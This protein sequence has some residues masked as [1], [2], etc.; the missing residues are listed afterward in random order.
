MRRPAMMR[1]LALPA[2]A[3]LL[4]A[5]VARPVAAIDGVLH[6]LP[7]ETT[8]E[9]SAYTCIAASAAGRVYVGT[10][11]YGGSG[12]LCELDPAVGQW[13]KVF[14]AHQLTRE[15]GVGLNSQSKFH[16]KIVIDAD[17]VVWAATKQGNEEFDTRPEYG[18]DPTGYPGGH[19][20]SYDP[21]TGRVT[22]HGIL[23]KQEGLMGGAVDNQRRR[24]YYW[25]DPKQHFL[26][27]DIAANKVTDKGNMGGSPRYTPIDRQGRVFGH[28][29]PARPDVMLMYDPETDKLSDLVIQLDGPG[30]YDVPYTTVLSADGKSLFCCSVVGNR[31]FE[32]DLA[33]VKLEPPGRETVP[34]TNGTIRVIDRGET[35]APPKGHNRH[36]GVLGADGCFY[37]QDWTR[38]IR[39]DPRTK[40]VEDLGEVTVGGQLWSETTYPN[41]A[42]VGPDGT[43]YGMYIYPLAVVELKGL[44]A[45][46]GGK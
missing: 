33:S 8:S 13:K 16:A 21:R 29:W 34:G 36:G 11:M 37:I 31:L 38:L 1:M 28:G 2:G 15:T 24:L 35:P 23:M 27:Y 10:A 17:G 43:F 25:S 41:G 46:Q 5:A 18:E 20:F 19:L 12:W 6:P 26:V 30:P 45:P 4:L 42:A 22:D 32:V 44:T 40:K 3:W 7:P 14:T 39:Y 9:G